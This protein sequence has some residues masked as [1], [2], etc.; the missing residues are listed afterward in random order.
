LKPFEG[1]SFTISNKSGF[2]KLGDHNFESTTKRSLNKAVNYWRVHWIDHVAGSPSRKPT[3]QKKINCTVF[4]SQN[5]GRTKVGMPHKP[6]N[7]GKLAKI[8]PS[9]PT[10]RVYHTLKDY[11]AVVHPGKMLTKKEMA[12][13]RDMDLLG[14]APKDCEVYVMLGGEVRR[15]EKQLVEA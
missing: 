4:C 12:L 6:E 1:H 15:V 5:K 8:K 9:V 10:G 3:V 7:L 14:A 13:L 11:C 2:I